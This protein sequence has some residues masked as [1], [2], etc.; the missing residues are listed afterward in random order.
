VAQTASGHTVAHKL[1][2]NS[3][4][5]HAKQKVETPSLAQII[6]ELEQTLYMVS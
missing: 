5:E 1:V 2:H 6:A 4:L 3:R